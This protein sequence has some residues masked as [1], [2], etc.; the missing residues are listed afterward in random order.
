MP[1][2]NSPAVTSHP[3]GTLP[4]GTAVER[5]TAVNGHIELC[6]LSYGG[7][8]TS[9]RAPDREGRPA[10]VVLGFD[11]LE[12]YLKNSAY[13]GALVGRYA[14]RIARGRFEL[15]GVL[16]QLA[17]ND[18]PN[19]LHGGDRG[20]SRRM[21]AAAPLVSENTAG[22]VLTRVSAD[23]EEHYPGALSVEVSY[24]LTADDTVVLRYTATTGATTIVNLTQ[25]T[26]F[27]LGGE[28]SASVL[29]HELTIH[30]DDYTPVGPTLIPTGTTEGVAWTPFDF[31]RPVRFG[32]RA[33]QRSHPQ[34]LAAGGFDH[35]F[36]LAHSTRQ[37]TPAAELRHPSTGRTLRVQTT[38]PGLQLYGGHLLDGSERGAY[39]R[40]FGPHAG[41]CLETQHF[42]DS[43]NHPQFPSVTL[44]PG[45]TYTSTTTWQFDAA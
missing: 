22:I 9:L 20:F 32:D 39:Q 24:L 27:N 16:H 41:L 43:P 21:W 15:D 33:Q 6:A 29:D 38:Q 12:P 26:Y 23:G 1:S 19:H 35:N 4:D 8:I 44:R 45:Q 14:N 11:R 28:T 42:P 18:G 36:V 7:I 2:R 3:F 10:D 37:R 17:T 31:R 13:F 30:A 40:V 5:F 25:H 34:L